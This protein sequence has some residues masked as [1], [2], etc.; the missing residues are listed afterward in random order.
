MTNDYENII[1]TINESVYILNK[2]GCFIEVN[3]GA[4]LM[5]GYT[6]KEII[7]KTPAFVS[8]PGKNDLEAVGRYHQRAY[9]GE[10]VEFEFWGLRKNGEI[11]PKK[12]TL[13]P[14][15]FRGKKVVIATGQDISEYKEAESKI[16]E[17]EQR[18]RLLHE[19]LPVGITL[20]DE[21]G[22][23]Y[24]V[25]ER[26]CIVLGYER[27][28]LIGKHIQIVSESDIE[29]I[30]LNIRRL[31]SGE[32][33]KSVTTALKKDGTREYVLLDERRI[34]LPDGQWGI[35]SIADFITSMVK[36][37]DQLQES[38]ETYKNLTEL[39]PEAVIVHSEGKF[40]FANRAAVEIIGAKTKKDL[41]GFPVLS[42]MHP[43]STK[44]AAERI[45]YMMESKNPVPPA[46]EKLVRFDGKTIITEIS[47]MPVTYH[48]KDA[49][50]TVIR[51]VTKEKEI[52]NAL[53][54]AKEKAEESDR[55]KTAFLQNMSHEI[56]TPLNAIIGFG[57]LIAT[58]DVSDSDQI[59]EYGQI[60][61]SN[62]KR[63]LELI[64]NILEV[65]KIESGVTEVKKSPVQLNSLLEEVYKTYRLEAETKGLDFVLKKGI[66]DFNATFVLD[67]AKLVQILNNL[68]GNALK[69]TK[70]GSITFG[71][72]L[73]GKMLEFFVSDTGKGISDADKEKI[74]QR[75]YQ[76]DYSFVRDFEGA[77]LGLSITQGLIQLIGGEIDVDS[78]PGKGTVFRFTLP[79]ERY[80]TPEIKKEEDLK[81]KG[82]AVVNILLAEDDESAARL[83][84]AFLNDKRF[85]IITARNGAEAVETVK[86]YPE[87]DLV[88]MDVKMP[89]L[90]GLDA[91]RQIKALRPELPVIATTAYAYENELK[92]ITEAGCDGVVTKPILKNELYKTLQKVCKKF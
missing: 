21:R 16:S 80:T 43:D 73:T 59:R 75:F 11:F 83:L 41:I 61:K 68:I 35:L 49:I 29:T 44:F 70:R 67:A 12:V 47:A 36:L 37:R 62:G 34:K 13:Y 66:D 90:N 60:I 88:L 23:I 33:L 57:D 26:F 24:D 91:T 48:G 71:Y 77:G 84:E 89:E 50:L 22:Y 54:K 53:K 56:R 39:L 4:E 79:A 86:K 51:D 74:F 78:V 63:L 92:M 55:L 45:K 28:E 3:R 10:T 69:F 40:L 6:K 15:T 76:A 58:D 32:V 72:E 27:D 17:S 31:L 1:N 52:L 65:S 2:E 85:F 14:G 8:A 87:I 20:L 7:G 25:N 42:I 38:E 19:F 5:Y 18:F 46:E 64:N 81:A 9:G 30:N 82:N